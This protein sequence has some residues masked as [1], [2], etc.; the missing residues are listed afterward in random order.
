MKHMNR[1]F[2]RDVADRVNAGER[3]EAGVGIPGRRARRESAAKRL[4]DT[5][6][7]KWQLCSF[8]PTITTVSCEAYS[9][10]II[11]HIGISTGR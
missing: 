7:H 1:F 5:F 10:E 3:R 6:D 2:G 9:L 11:G 4:A 8:G